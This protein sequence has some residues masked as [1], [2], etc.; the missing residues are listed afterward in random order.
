MERDG[1]FSTLALSITKKGV[2]ASFYLN[3]YAASLHCTV[4]YFKFPKKTDLNRTKLL[5]SHF[6]HSTGNVP[7]Y[8][9]IPLV[10]LRQAL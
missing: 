10:R 5:A 8:E 4:L 9:K 3:Q 6:F 1:P 2:V 7:K